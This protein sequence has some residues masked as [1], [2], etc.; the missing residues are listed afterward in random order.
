MPEYK[1]FI[2]NPETA[3]SPELLHQFLLAEVGAKLLNSCQYRIEKKSIDARSRQLK[4]NVKIGF[5]PL[6]HDFSVDLHSRQVTNKLK[7]NAPS[8]LIIGSG[9]AGLFAA[10]TLIKSGI[11][12]IVI[13]RGNNV[14]DRRR[15]L[16]AI[17][18]HNVVNAESNYCFGEG[19]SLIHI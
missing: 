12:P 11:K 6:E 16:A 15:D 1:S 5:Y 3:H 4:A 13:E 9:P 17:N 10:L 19:L 18:K 2:L 7:P 14:R 8:V